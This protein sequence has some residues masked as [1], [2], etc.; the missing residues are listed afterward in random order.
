M[1][2]I[3][4][5]RARNRPL[6]DFFTFM[7]APRRRGS[8]S[9]SSARPGLQSRNSRFTPVPLGLQGSGRGRRADINSGGR[10]LGGSDPSNASGGLTES[11]TLP[12]YEVKGGPPN[13]AQFLAVDLGMGA[14]AIHQGPG[15]TDQSAQPS[16]G[17]DAQLPHP[18]PPSYI[19]GTATIW[20]PVPLTP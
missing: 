16:H 6:Q 12:A 1:S 9:P 3:R 17:L 18:P 2:R 15:M 19:R 8:L 13:Y 5:L 14:N 4:F 20:H 10:Q 11:D 7:E